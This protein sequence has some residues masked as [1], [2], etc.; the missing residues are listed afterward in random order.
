[1]LPFLAQGAAQAIEDGATLAA[2]LVQS[3]ADI[4]AALR[5]YE[6]LRR[7]RTARIQETARGNKRRN[8]L[9]DGP[10]QRARDEAMAGGKADWSIGASAWVYDHDAAA[11]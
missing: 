2:V 10:E 5:R 9:P 8:H 7:P 4:P 11:V 6:E 1:M 3:S